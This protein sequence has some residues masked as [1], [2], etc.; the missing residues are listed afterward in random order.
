[1][2]T[3]MHFGDGTWKEISVDSDDPQEAVWEAAD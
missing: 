1:M 3:T 2:K